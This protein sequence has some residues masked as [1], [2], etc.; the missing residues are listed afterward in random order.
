M[1]QPLQTLLFTEDSGIG[2]A[3]AYLTP[4]V[5]ITDAHIRLVVEARSLMREGKYA[6]PKL[7][8]WD[9]SKHW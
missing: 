1:N 3:I 6:E 5:E 9:A 4:D 2:G 7:P 8:W